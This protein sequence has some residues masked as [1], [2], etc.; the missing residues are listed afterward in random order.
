MAQSTAPILR[1]RLS[2]FVNTIGERGGAGRTVSAFWHLRDQLSA[3]LDES[4][5]FWDEPKPPSIGTFVSLAPV[6]HHWATLGR[7]QPFNKNKPLALGC[8]G[9]VGEARRRD[10]LDLCCCL[11]LMN[12]LKREIGSLRLLP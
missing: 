12:R 8:P 5:R 2:S 3:F 7:Y 4:M 9:P 1:P 10:A 6:P 11:H